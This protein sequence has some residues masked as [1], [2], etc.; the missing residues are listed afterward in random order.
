MVM[1][2]GLW[3]SCPGG[4]CSVNGTGQ[5]PPFEKRSSV[6]PKYFAK[7]RRE[8]ELDIETPDAVE[9]V[10]HKMIKVSNMPNDTNGHELIQALTS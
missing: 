8:S 1:A 10:E 2:M 7:I 9:S 5:L 4:G 6:S 3:M